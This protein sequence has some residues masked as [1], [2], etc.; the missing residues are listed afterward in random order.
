[1]NSHTR[2][3][4]K[5]PKPPSDEVADPFVDMLNEVPKRPEVRKIE[6]VLNLL[7][8]AETCLRGWKTREEV[9]DAAVDRSDFHTQWWNSENCRIGYSEAL[10]ELNKV[11]RRYSWISVIIGDITGFKEEIGL[12]DPYRWED[13]FIRVILDELRELRRRP[14][15]FISSYRKCVEC[16]RWFMRSKRG[17]RGHKCCGDNCRK[18]FNS[19]NPD[20]KKKRA[21]YMRDV[22]RPGEREREERSRQQAS[23][24]LKGKGGS[25]GGISRRKLN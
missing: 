20:Y 2:P 13:G 7:I 5:K 15:G 4:H 16:D 25:S 3:L 19:R 9:S 23:A 17:P 12:D 24:M 14:R 11:L 18:R 8:R 1:M 22:Y 10:G 6:N 21:N